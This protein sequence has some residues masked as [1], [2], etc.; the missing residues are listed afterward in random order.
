MGI[1]S[2]VDTSLYTSPYYAAQETSPFQPIRP[3][4]ENDHKTSYAAAQD[5]DAPEVDLSSYY[6][7]V[8]PSEYNSD[9]LSY[10]AQAEHNFGNAVTEALT[11]GMNPQS[12]V[13]LQLAKVAYIASMQVAEVENSTFEFIV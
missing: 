6:S 10:V 1:L 4:G 13:N 8:Q 7:N 5:L 9:A 3:V 12:A 2:S 11:N